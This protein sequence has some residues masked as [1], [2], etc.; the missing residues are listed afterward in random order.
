MFGLFWLGKNN[1]NCVILCHPLLT[2]IYQ[3]RVQLKNEKWLR[4]ALCWTFICFSRNCHSPVTRPFKAS[5]LNIWIPIISVLGHNLVINL[6]WEII[7]E[8]SK[9]LI[10]CLIW[11]KF[12]PPIWFVY[13]LNPSIWFEIWIVYLHYPPVQMQILKTNQISNQFVGLKFK[14]N[15][16]LW[17]LWDDFSNQIYDQIVT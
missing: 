10:W 4:I 6:V 17:C 14:S 1:E 8:T 5:K 12:K 3:W 11:L 15:Q 16:I 9:Y 7:S 13:I 2:F